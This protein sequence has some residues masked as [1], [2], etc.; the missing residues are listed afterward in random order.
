MVGSLA[1]TLEVRAIAVSSDLIYLGCKGGVVEVWC[2]EK[3]TRVEALQTGTNGKV[4]CMA[5]DSNEELLVIG[6]AD[7][8]ILVIH[9]S[10]P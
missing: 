2:K 5:L 1:S 9:L 4:L 7:G 10:G 6:T 8:K 3:H